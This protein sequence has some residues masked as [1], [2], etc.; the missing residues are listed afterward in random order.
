MI[1]VLI[2]FAFLF[3]A[4]LTTIPCHADHWRAG[5]AK[6]KITPSEPMLMAGYGS[7]TEPANGKLTELWAKALVI[8]DASGHK[9]LIITLDLV[10]I[11]RGLSQ[12][13]CQTLQSKHHLT[14]EQISICASHTHTGPAVGMN[15]GPLH[16]LVANA[17]QQQQ[18]D[19]YTV[20][21]HDRIV[22]VADEAMKTLAPAQLHWGSGRCDFAVNRRENKP[23]ENVPQWRTEGVLKGPVDH[24]VPVLTVRNEQ[25]ELR[26]ILFGYACHATVLGVRQWSG[27]YPGFAQLELEKRHPDCVALFWAGCG[28]DQNPLPRKSVELAKHYGRRL[29][30]AVDSVVLTSAMTPITGELLTAYKEIELPLSE[31]PSESQLSQDA[32][33]TNRFIA[34]RAK[35]LL[36][37]LETAPLKQ[38]YPYPVS[39]WKIGREIQFISLGGEVVVDY[40]IRLKSELQGI[41]TWVA[42][43]A[44]DVMAYIPS[45]RVLTEGGYEGGGAM[46]YYGLPTTW[47]PEVEQNIV[48]EVGEQLKQLHRQT[49]VEIGSRLELFVDD[50]L[51]DSMQG[52]IARKLI[53][54]EPKEVVFVTDQPWEGNTSGYYSLFRDGDLYRMIY[55]G[56]QH[57]KNKKAAHPEVTCYAES[58]DGVHWEKPNLGLFEW[59]GSKDNNIVWLGP[60]THNL[61][62][63]R[64]TNP[65]ADPNAQYKAFGGSGGQGGLS[66]GLLPF[67]SADCKQ[68]RVLQKDPVITNGAF[69]SQNLALWDADRQEY[70]AYWRYFG[71][72]VRA[73]RTATSKDF[74]VWEGEADLT[75]PAETPTEHL[76][77]NAIQTY[78]RAPHLF[79]GFPTRYEP[80]SQQVEPILMTSRDGVH[81]NRW[82]D[83]VVPRTAPKDRN[84]NRSNYMAWGMFQLPGKP[85]EISVY[86]TENYYEETPGRLRRFVYRTDGFVAVRANDDG[87]TLTTRLLTYNGGELQLNYKTNAGGSLLVKALDRDGTVLAVSAPIRGDAIDGRVQWERPIDKNAAAIRLQIEMRNADLFSMRFAP[88]SKD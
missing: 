77:T 49:A 62:A 14:R 32:Q 45:R 84:H 13:V 73:I 16:Y 36:K 29:A 71:N 1:R 38:T 81:F 61:T 42:G 6:A 72:G 10:G 7:R 54:P 65:A 68:W 3:I 52:D 20:Q 55:R 26:S 12:K 50:H 9:G 40:A 76:Y 51:I 4:S 22:S 66:R 17:R 39:C 69:D 88:P 27:D 47:A 34:A 43:Y 18:I 8:E 78:F 44:N 80:K 25:G 56:W 21:L 48:A 83:P 5:V 33:S 70:R 46:V 87:G 19:Q 53:L 28:A 75:Y 74:L 85:N 64:D 67:G 63:M 37:Q 35:M 41:K 11:D 86:A 24:D 31:L 15:L 2:A 57:D 30:E 79:I 82:S 60:G 58:K 23:Y 59:Q